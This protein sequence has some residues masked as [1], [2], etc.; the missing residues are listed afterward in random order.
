MPERKTTVVRAA[1]AEKS[2]ASAS[3]DLP[4]RPMSVCIA[5]GGIG[6][7]VLAVALLKMGFMV[8]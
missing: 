6:G 3:T 4:Q 1:V 5:G 8:C 7:L 2:G